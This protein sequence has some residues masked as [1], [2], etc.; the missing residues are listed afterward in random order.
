MMSLEGTPR[1]RYGLFVL[2]ILMLLGGA[3]ALFFAW[4]S[5]TRRIEDFVIWLLGLLMIVASTYLVRMSNVRA[6]PGAVAGGDQVS[7]QRTGKRP[8]ALLWLM[9]AASVVALVISYHYL[10]QD[11]LGGYHEV[12]PVDVFAA[13][14]LISATVLAYLFSRLV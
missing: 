11:A 13:V 5:F 8:G 7:G 1:K 14:A 9:G 12:W 6:R 3:A 10:Y 4:A 2:A